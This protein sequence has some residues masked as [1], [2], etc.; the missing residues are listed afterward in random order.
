[1]TVVALH[2]LRQRLYGPV[3]VD[4]DVPASA[5]AV[6]A[7]LSDP[8]T[9]P[10]WLVGA[11]EIREVDGD[12]PAAGSEFH[13]SVGPTEDLTVDDTTESLGASPGRHVA[14]AVR[15]GPMRGRVDFDLA[16]AGEDGD[17][18]VRFS[19]QPTGPLAV[20]TPLLRPT[21][22]ARNLESLRRLRAQ[23]S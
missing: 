19:E 11:Q 21:L 6:Y 13:H 12:F 18:R 16:P 7:M 5:D 22:A 8:T 23:L 20:L 15:A 1:M 2:R 9:Y 17:T 4:L 10:D 3:V 14:L